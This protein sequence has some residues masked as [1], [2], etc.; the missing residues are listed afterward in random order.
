MAPG[1]RV[2]M[3]LGHGGLTM[4]FALTRSAYRMRGAYSYGKPHLALVIVGRR[5]VWQVGAFY[6]LAYPKSGGAL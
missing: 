3:A 1:L 5:R 6:V 2:V 4:R